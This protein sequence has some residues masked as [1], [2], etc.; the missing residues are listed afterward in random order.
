VQALWIE[1]Q[2]HTTATDLAEEM[3]EASM[4]QQGR[5]TRQGIVSTAAALALTAA[6]AHVAIAAA[7]TPAVPPAARAARALSVNDTGYLHLLNSSGSILTEEGPVSGTL[8]GTAR[9]RLDVG[10]NVTASFTIRVRGGG[11]ITGT[12]HATLHSSGRYTSFGGTLL[13]T[14]GTGRYAHAHG[15][16]KL[17]GVIERKS[18]DLTVQTREGTLHY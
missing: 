15:A 8:P 17:Y 3:R 12:G 2:T 10:E 1:E 7:R 9:V 14:R 5:P 6:C 13:V 4:T 11:S 18:E 16:G